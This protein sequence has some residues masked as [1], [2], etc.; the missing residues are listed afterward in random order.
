MKHKHKAMKPLTFRRCLSR[1]RKCVRILKTITPDNPAWDG[2]I[3]QAKYWK[4]LAMD[5]ATTN[6]EIADASQI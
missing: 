1:A 3:V 2:L 4:G 6:H 5:K